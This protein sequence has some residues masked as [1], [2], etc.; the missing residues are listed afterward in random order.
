[1]AFD[2]TMTYRNYVD[3]EA[4]MPKRNVPEI[5]LLSCTTC[6][7]ALPAGFLKNQKSRTCTEDSGVENISQCGR[8]SQLRWLFGAL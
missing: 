7:T 6:I 3:F 4:K 5:R 1:M 2:K 8:L